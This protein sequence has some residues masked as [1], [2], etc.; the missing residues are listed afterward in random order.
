M[1]RVYKNGASSTDE[2]IN[3]PSSTNF[4]AEVSEGV[5]NCCPGDKVGHFIEGEQIPSGA[6]S[7]TAISA[8]LPQQRAGLAQEV[9]LLKGK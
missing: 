4:K 5:G 8:Y 6:D 1:S 9:Q 3:M 2:S 7:A